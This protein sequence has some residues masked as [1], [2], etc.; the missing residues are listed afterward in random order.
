MEINS[1]I[2]KVHKQAELSEALDSKQVFIIDNAEITIFEKAY[3]DKDDG[4]YDVIYKGGIT[5]AI[6]GH[7]GEKVIRGVDKTKK[8]RKLRGAVWHLGN[9]EGVEDQ[10]VFYDLFMD[11][12]IANA[13]G[14]WRFLKDK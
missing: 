10:E 7:Q 5:S 2:L 4:T 8:S 11:K 3:R 12:L 1:H 6:T 13:D 14:V 9:D